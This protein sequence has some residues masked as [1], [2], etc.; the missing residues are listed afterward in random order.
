MTYL[1][2]SIRLMMLSMM[3]LLSGTAESNEAK[4][5]KPSSYIKFVD[6]RT[7][8]DKIPQFEVMW[9]Y[10]M[11]VVDEES[12]SPGRGRNSVSE[13]LESDDS[14][15]DR[16]FQYIQSA[17]ESRK[18]ADKETFASICPNISDLSSRNDL[19]AELTKMQ[20]ES[21]EGRDSLVQGLGDLLTPEENSR[22]SAW[23]DSSFRES[24]TVSTV[25]WYEFLS[26][27]SVN[28]EDFK[29]RMCPDSYDGLHINQRS[30]SN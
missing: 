29:H 13:M 19:A 17:V 22:L 11:S 20:K 6:G 18:I 21:D 5:K 4:M 16:V 24:L 8:P 12:R 1:H 27:D 14:Q 30:S 25:D 26:Q 10:F 2:S 15:T 3:V 7:D 9:M 23:S 28:L